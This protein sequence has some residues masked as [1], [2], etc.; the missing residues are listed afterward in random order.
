ML[1][2]VIL[3]IVSLLSS[4]G[5]IAWR[6]VMLGNF[7]DAENGFLKPE[8]HIQGYVF[9]G[10]IIV[11][12][13][14][15]LILSLVEKDY[16]VSPRKHS[17]LNM[18]VSFILSATLF[19]EGFDNIRQFKGNNIYLVADLLLFATA[20]YFLAYGSSQLMGRR[21]NDL[22]SLIPVIYFLVNLAIVF[23]LSFKIV[24]SQEKLMDTFTRI[25]IVLY[26]ELFSKY[27][28]KKNFKKIRKLFLGVSVITSTVA[29]TYGGSNL[30]CSIIYSDY[31]KARGFSVIESAVF[32]AV[33][34]FCLV[35]ACSSFLKKDTYS[36][37]RKSRYDGYDEEDVMDEILEWDSLKNEKE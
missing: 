11:L 25:C 15:F 7:T 27:L 23:V 26:F 4:I 17:Y 29:L 8:Y 28:S 32:F 1:K 22:F 10:V 19:I 3:L 21:L 36:K 34:L 12:M 13:A 37:W 5:L 9:A 35:F 2:K 6:T 14:V 20:V 31:A 18:I 30:L 33:G 24:N 16:P